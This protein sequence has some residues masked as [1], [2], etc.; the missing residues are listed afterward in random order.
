MYIGLC[1]LCLGIVSLLQTVLCLPSKPSFSLNEVT[2]RPCE[3]ENRTPIAIG[4]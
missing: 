2:K 4:P 3:A 1:T